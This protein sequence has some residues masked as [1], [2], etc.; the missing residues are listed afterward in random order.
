MSAAVIAC[1]GCGAKNRVE[2]ERASRDTPKCGRCG[3]TLPVRAFGGVPVEVSDAN[4]AAEVLS[5]GPV[6]VLVDCWAAWCGP[7]KMIAPTI[8]QLAAE[9]AG[10][11]KVAKLDVDAN[12]RTAAT[13]RI[14]GIP[15]LLLFKDGRLVDQMV[16]VQPK[17]AIAARLAKWI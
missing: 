3:T 2:A 13:Y 7:C 5:A 8:D 10:R 16:G 15:A 4:F 6:P 1:P 14:E 17:P 12:Q 11:Y 9:A